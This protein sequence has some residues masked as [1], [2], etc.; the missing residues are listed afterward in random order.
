MPSIDDRAP[1][2]QS[3]ISPLELFS[4]VEVA[5][6][7]KHSHTFGAPVYVL[8]NAL[9]TTGSGIPKWKSRANMGIY[10]GTSP[11]HARKIALVLN[12]VTGHVSLQ[13]HVVIDDF[14]ETLRPST[15]N[16]IPKSDWQKMTGFVKGADV[17]RRNLSHASEQAQMPTMEQEPWLDVT[18]VTAQAIQQNGTVHSVP[19]YDNYNGAINA[20]DTDLET[21]HNMPE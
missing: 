4:Q 2:I 1:A 21:S 16:A 14:F 10:V 7:V 3:G 12:L 20:T 8:E 15:G 5:P 19:V 18:E 11:R 17:G 9:Q 6:E 13:F